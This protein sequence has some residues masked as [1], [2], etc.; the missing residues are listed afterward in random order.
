VKDAGAPTLNSVA[1]AFR[2]K[3]VIA[4]LAV[5]HGLSNSVDRRS[6]TTGGAIAM[7][8]EIVKLRGDA[9]TAFAVFLPRNDVFG[10]PNVR[11]GQSVPPHEVDFYTK[12]DRGTETYWAYRFDAEKRTLQR[13]DYDDAGKVGV[14]DRATGAIDAAGSYPALTGVKAFSAQRLEASELTSGANVFG[15]LV[16][17]LVTPGRPPQADPVGFIPATGLP[18]DDLYGG[19][20]T[21]QVHESSG[22]SLITTPAACM[23]A[24]RVSPSSFCAWVKSSRTVGRVSASSVVCIHPCSLS[25]ENSH[26][27]S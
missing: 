25:S 1:S 26:S 23:P 10:Q 17:Q 22:P 5:A 18:R 24:C 13:Y 19:N 14:A 3:I 2:R 11:A 7:E 12:T 20:V 6:A 21:V 9:D 27:R 8:Q 4:T 15:N 16:A